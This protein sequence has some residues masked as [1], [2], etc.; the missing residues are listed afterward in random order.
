MK[1]DPRRFAARPD[2]AAMH[3]KGEVEAERFAEATQMVVSVPAAPLTSRPDGDA[4]LESQ[5]L[6]GEP[7]AAYEMAGGWAWGQ[8]E[9]DG[10]VGYVPHA[11]LLPA[12]PVPTHR[13]TQPTTLVYAT[14]A[15]KTRPIGWLSYGALVGVDGVDNNFAV[16]TAGGFVPAPHLSPCDA[17]A[18]DWVAEA[19]RFLGAPYLW[20]GRTQAGLDCSALV[21]LA[22]QAAGRDCPRDSD[23]QAA[24]LGRTLAPGTAHER[25]D[26]V[27]WTGHVGIMLDRTRML[28][29]SGNYMTVVVETLDT[30]IE[31]ILAAGEGPVI[32][33]ARLDATAAES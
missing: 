4:P 3:L 27:F 21:Q 12:G 5:I 29:S 11:C 19:E 25:G 10:Y 1:Q 23:M 33:H 16:L 26:L 7:Y 9:R 14:P 20:G 32:R 28:Q 13:V 24:D 22:L 30:A 17:F 31:R 2:L 18:P 15:V 8:S 6:Y